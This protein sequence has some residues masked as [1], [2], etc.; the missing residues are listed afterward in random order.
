MSWTIL[1]RRASLPCP[2]S[3]V[4]IPPSSLCPSLLAKKKDG[5][6]RVNL[7][8]MVDDADDQVC[9][10]SSRHASIC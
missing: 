2:S 5:S 3:T 8:D 6:K 1:M 9:D 10:A 4:S 7:D